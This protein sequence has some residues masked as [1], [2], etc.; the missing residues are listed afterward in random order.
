M[1][2]QLAAILSMGNIYEKL[3]CVAGYET[4]SKLLVDFSDTHHKTLVCVDN[5]EESEEDVEEN[6]LKEH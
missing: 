2:V 3:F 4:A 5:V 1:S 6:H